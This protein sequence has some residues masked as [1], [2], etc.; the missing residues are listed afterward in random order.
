[1]ADNPPRHEPP[2]PPSPEK[3]VRALHA[4]GSG[5]NRFRLLLGLMPMPPRPPPSPPITGIWGVVVKVLGSF[6]GAGFLPL[7][8]GTWGSLAALAIWFLG[9][10]AAIAAGMTVGQ[11]DVGCFL[12]SAI[13]AAATLALGSLAERAA[14]R[15][16]PPWFVLDE[17]SG[18]FLALYGL[19][20]Y[21]HAPLL[22]SAAGAF[23]LFRVLDATKLGVI[24]WADRR[25]TGGVG[26]LMDDLFAGA[27]ATLT[28]RGVAWL[29][30]GLPPAAG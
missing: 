30:F 12:L 15:Y 29:L 9:R 24:G 21:N 3:P 7:A 16:D 11:M 26:I 25:L 10:D 28:V 22:L 13:F 17:L 20:G 23:L 8:P 19:A 6:F 14:G 2:A 1:M 18:A 27:V 5:S 4:L